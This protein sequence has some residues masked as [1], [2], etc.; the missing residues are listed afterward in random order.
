MFGDA[1]QAILRSL[2]VAVVGAGGGGS[3]L[4]EQLAHLGVGAITVVDYDVVKEINLSRIVGSTPADVGIKK[5]DVL[6]RLVSSIDSAVCFTGIDGDIANLSVAQKLLRCDF[7]FLATDTITS[8]LVFNSIVHRYLIPGVQIGAKIDTDKA[9]RISEIY[10]AV[11]P[12]LPDSGC[13]E[14]NSLIDPMALQRESRTDEE[15]AAQNYL[16]EPDVTDPSVISLNGLAASHAVNVMLLWA[17][18][19]SEPSLLQHRLFLA[20]TGEALVVNDRRDSGCAYCSHTANSMY[21]AGGPAELLPCRRDAPTET[22]D[23]RPRPASGVR[24][25]FFHRLRRG[26]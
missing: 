7:I 1:G 20:R 24:R 13:L 11:R 23:E 12:V 6:R 26:R 21:A 16:N 25:A 2:N 8:R 15:Q 22:P 17:T 18:G 4:V 14:C 3:M 9:G 19:L 10:V 5:V